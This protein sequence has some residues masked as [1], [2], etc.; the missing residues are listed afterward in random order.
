[1]SSCRASHLNRIHGPRGS[2]ATMLL[3]MLRRTRYL[4]PEGEASSAPFCHDIRLQM[5][6]RALYWP[7][8]VDCQVQDPMPALVSH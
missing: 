8:C 6:L 3:V 7:A 5:L 2:S 1:M 4:I